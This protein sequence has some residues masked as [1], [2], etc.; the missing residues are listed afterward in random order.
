MEQAEIKIKYLVWVGGIYNEFGSFHDAI[1]DQF[2][3]QKK[4][5]DDVIIQPIR[6][7]Y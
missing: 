2:E 6:E 5:Y 3:W 4:G 7:A 1:M